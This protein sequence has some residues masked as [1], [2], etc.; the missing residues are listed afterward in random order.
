MFVISLAFSNPKISVGCEHKG[1][2]FSTWPKSQCAKHENKTDL[3]SRGTD[4]RLLSRQP[5]GATTSSY[6]L[7]LYQKLH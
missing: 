2:L 7:F 5:W 1:I 6:H 4:G 3:S